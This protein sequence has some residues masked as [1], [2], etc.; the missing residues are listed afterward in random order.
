MKK[1]I[2]AILT[3]SFHLQMFATAQTPDWLI[4]KGDTIAIFTNPLEQFENI[5][6]LR[7]ELKLYSIS[8]D[9]WRGYTAE[10]AIID[11]QLYLMGIYGCHSNRRKGGAKIDWGDFFGERHINGKIKAD[12]FTGNIISPQG[13][14]LHY[15]H[16]GYESLYERELE[17]RFE[18]GILTGTELYSNKIKHSVYN[19]DRVKL[20]EYIYSNINWN[21]LPKPDSV[22]KIKVLVKVS[23]NEEGIIDMAEI[24]RGYN[25]IYD[26]EAI[27]VVK[28]IPEW[29][30]YYRRGGKIRYYWA[31]PI[32]FNF[33]EGNE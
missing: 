15:E 20:M 24:V 23:A 3:F 16:M 17:F 32:I 19:Q 26:Q 28:S 33:N 13:E 25:E 21:I 22:D 6:S 31:I 30:I 1:I 29:E 7:S 8:T 4:Y 10:W 14:L 11:N 18:N 27:R 2:I 12:W 5:D 9:C